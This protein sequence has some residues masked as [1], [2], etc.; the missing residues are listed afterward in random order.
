MDGG[1]LL[2]ACRAGA[3]SNSRGVVLWPL[4]PSHFL[5]LP[6]PLSNPSPQAPNL[7]DISG[8]ANFF[9]K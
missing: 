5:H 4:P 1:L 8:G 9:A 7:M 3:R 6:Y 2:A